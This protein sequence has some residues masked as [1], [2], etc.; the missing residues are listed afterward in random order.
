MMRGREETGNVNHIRSTWP[1]H[2]GPH[3]AAGR[4]GDRAVAHN[5]HPRRRRLQGAWAASAVEYGLGGD[6]I[7]GWEDHRTM[8]GAGAA[9]GF[10]WILSGVPRLSRLG[11][12]RGKHIWGDDR[13]HLP[14]FCPAWRREV[15]CAQHG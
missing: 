12:H 6:G 2:R 9:D 13:R 3:L 7:S 10:L 1:S 8:S 11:E 14:E 15:L 5:P 4:A